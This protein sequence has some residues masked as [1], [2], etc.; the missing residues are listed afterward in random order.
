MRRTGT[1]REWACRAKILGTLE[2]FRN[3]YGGGGHMYVT[4]CCLLSRY[5]YLLMISLKNKHVL[6]GDVAGTALPGK[7]L[8]VGMCGVL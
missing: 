4:N 7:A 5:L 3:I 8:T 2:Y 6:F 1:E